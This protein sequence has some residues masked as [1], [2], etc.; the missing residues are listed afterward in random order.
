MPTISAVNS[1]M[2][3]LVNKGETIDLYF[4]QTSSAQ[5]EKSWIKTNLGE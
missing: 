2:D 4:G 5:G 3:L 1:N